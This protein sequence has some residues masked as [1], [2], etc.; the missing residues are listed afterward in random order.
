MNE[1]LKSTQEDDTY[2][3]FIRKQPQWSDEADF[4]HPIKGLPIDGKLIGEY[5]VYDSGYDPVMGN[6][7]DECVVDLYEGF[8]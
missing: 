4:Y 3:R 2:C 6:T 7:Y 5:A 8:K 1:Y